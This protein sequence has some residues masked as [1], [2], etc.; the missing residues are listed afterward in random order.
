MQRQEPSEIQSGGVVRLL[1]AGA[2]FVHNNHLQS[3]LRKTRSCG[4]CTTGLAGAYAAVKEKQ[5]VDK[6]D[7]V[8]KG[9]GADRDGDPAYSRDFRDYT[10]EPEN[11]LLEKGE[12]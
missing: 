8:P 12:F 6:E 9:D 4:L 11:Q 2:V 3:G 5:P 10:P 1:N 7:G